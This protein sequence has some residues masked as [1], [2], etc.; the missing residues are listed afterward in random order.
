MKTKNN[1]AAV[2]LSAV[3]FSVGLVFASPPAQAQGGIRLW[4]NRYN[5]PTNTYSNAKALAVDASGNV[6]VTGCSGVGNGSDFDYVTI[7]Y[8]NAGAPLWTN[9]YAGPGNGWD[10][11][12]CIVVDSSGDVIVTGISDHSGSDSSHTNF[13]Y[14]TIKYSN[15]GVPLWTNRYNGPGNAHDWPASVAVDASGNVFV[16]GS[17]I[18]SG[19]ESDYATIKYSNAGATLWEK[20]FAIPTRHNAYARSLAVASNGDVFVTGYV[21][22]TIV[23]GAREFATV[24][25]SSSGV[26]LWTNLFNEPGSNDSEPRAIAVDRSGT[27][28]VT[29]FSTSTDTNSSTDAATIAYS[30]AG[31]WLWTSFYTG[32]TGYR[33]GA[34]AVAVDGN[35]NVFVTGESDTSGT[36]PVLT[37]PTTIL[38]QSSILPSSRRRFVLPDDQQP[39]HA[40]CRVCNRTRGEDL[41]LEIVNY[42][43]EMAR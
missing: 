18:G 29:G 37:T 43:W 42:G 38:W 7:K 3:I 15:A 36:Y 14:A 19:T 22:E 39:A 35:G 13:D 4:T 41:S 6:F 31:V 33:D 17:S 30:A 16:T 8:S 32:P 27:V 20:R 21:E 34:N 26:P 9:R 1:T 11:P 28:F 23:S 10:D 5:G 12:C 40:S 2:L 25:Y 24:A